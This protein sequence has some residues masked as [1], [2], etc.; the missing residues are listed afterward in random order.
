MSA[1]ARPQAQPDPP[2]GRQL[3]RRTH[4]ALVPEPATVMLPTIGMAGPSGFQATL[5]GE[6]WPAL[7]MTQFQQPGQPII[8]WWEIAK[9]EAVRFLVDWK[10]KLHLQGEDYQRPYGSMYFRMDVLGR[11]AAVVVLASTCNTWV[12]KV[13]GLR[14]YDCVDLARICRSPDRRCAGARCVDAAAQQNVKPAAT[15]NRHQ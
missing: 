2:T 9:D 3:G 14:R 12:S 5:P 6:C 7:A 8:G 10:H 15:A 1:V 4:L 11:P 13:H